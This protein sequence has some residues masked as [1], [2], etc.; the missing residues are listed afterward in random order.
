[1]CGGGGGGGVGGGRGAMAGRWGRE[2]M[3]GYVLQLRLIFASILS[4]NLNAKHAG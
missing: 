1:M 3:C 4:Q 2:D